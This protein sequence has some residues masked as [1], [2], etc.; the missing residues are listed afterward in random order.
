M[1]EA[2]L[3]I[4]MPG[5]LRKHDS[6][7]LPK[8]PFCQNQLTEGSGREQGTFLM[9]KEMSGQNSLIRNVERWEQ[10]LSGP[11]HFPFNYILF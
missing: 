4:T 9:E 7:S 10:L 1:N 6:L 3:L 2:S 8:T 5:A 11:S